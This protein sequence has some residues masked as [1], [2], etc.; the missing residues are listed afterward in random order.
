MSAWTFWA[1]CVILECPNSYPCR[2]STLKK[3]EKINWPT[4]FDTKRLAENLTLMIL[5]HTGG[6]EGLFWL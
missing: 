1:S 3:S 6:N 2:S 5:F 4:K